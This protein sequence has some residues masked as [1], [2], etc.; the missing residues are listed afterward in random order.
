MS[1][2]KEAE[3]FRWD[4]WQL[5]LGKYPTI[6]QPHLFLELLFFSFLKLFPLPFLLGPRAFLLISVCQFFSGIHS[7]IP[8]RQCFVNYTFSS[9]PYS[10]LLVYPIGASCIV[11]LMLWWQKKAD[12]VKALSSFQSRRWKRI[13]LN[14]SW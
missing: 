4:M 12:F 9:S 6:E 2:Q 10:L 11:C 14:Y 13:G 3:C 8:S 7:K 1:P 5:L